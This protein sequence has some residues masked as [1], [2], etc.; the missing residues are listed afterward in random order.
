[1]ARIKI[2]TD[3]DV[4]AGLAA[5]LREAGYDAVSINEINRKGLADEEQLA[6]AVAESRALLT[7]NVQ[8]FGPLAEM[9]F[10]QGIPHC[11]IL[12]ARQ[13]DK[14]ELL[15]R[16]LQLLDS[17]TSEQMANTLRFV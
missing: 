13:F 3:E 6:F 8:D 14:R 9:C 10:K 15:R 11:G 16:T 4:W 5:A 12:V 2:L 7:H 17:L 1:M